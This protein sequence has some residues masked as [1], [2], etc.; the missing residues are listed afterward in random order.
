MNEGYPKDWVKLTVMISPDGKDIHAIGGDRE[1]GEGDTAF[2]GLELLKD[3]LYPEEKI[4][5]DKLNQQIK[6]RMT[7]LNA[8]TSWQEPEGKTQGNNDMP[9]W[10]K[11]PRFSCVESKTSLPAGSWQCSCFYNG[12]WVT[13]STGSYCGKCGL[14]APGCQPVDVRDVEL[15]SLRSAWKAQKQ[16]TDELREMLRKLFDNGYRIKGSFGEMLDSPAFRK[17]IASQ[18]TLE[19]GE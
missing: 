3:R 6:Q 10:M 5:R 12:L 15:K 16:Q 19:G 11:Q 7:E 4:A 1:P 9:E 13:H 8:N 14:Y 2:I 18:G 17:A